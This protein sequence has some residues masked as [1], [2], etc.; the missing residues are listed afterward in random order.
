[1]ERRLISKAGSGRPYGAGRPAGRG[2]GG[3]RRKQ[4]DPRLL[5]ITRFVK[6]AI[7]TTDSEPFDPKHRFADFKMHDSLKR[8]VYT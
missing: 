5:D 4:V 1:M 8:N 7:V 6:K 3:G 2:G